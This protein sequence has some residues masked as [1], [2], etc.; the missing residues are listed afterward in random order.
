MAGIEEMPSVAAVFDSVRRFHVYDHKRG[1]WAMTGAD[2]GERCVVSHADGEPGELTEFSNPGVLVDGSDELSLV[3]EDGPSA[4]Y[5]TASIDMESAG[6]IA[7]ELIDEIAELV[8][9]DRSRIRVA[10]LEAPNRVS[11]FVTPEPIGGDD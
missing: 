8:D 3:W 4:E 5:K 1:R 9:V 2:F 6:D 10:S 7:E 11:Y